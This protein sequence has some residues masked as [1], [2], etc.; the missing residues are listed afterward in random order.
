MGRVEPDSRW[1]RSVA[2]FTGTAIGVISGVVWELVVTLNLIRVNAKKRILRFH[3]KH[4]CYYP[5]FVVF[6]VWFG[7]RQEVSGEFV[8][9]R[10][11][12]FI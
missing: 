11:V 5:L 2:S 9:S 6:S 8:F 4:P 1:C 3:R 7:V 10:A 12:T